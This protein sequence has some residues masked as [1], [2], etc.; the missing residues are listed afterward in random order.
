EGNEFINSWAVGFFPYEDPTYVF[1]TLLEHGPHS[2]LFGSA[3]TMS[4]VIDW[5][6]RNRPEYLQ[7]EVAVP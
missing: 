6:V 2:N 1:V 3:P 7:N 4:G 5:M